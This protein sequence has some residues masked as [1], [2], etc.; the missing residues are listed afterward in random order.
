VEVERGP[1]LLIISVLLVLVCLLVLA[2]AR[3]AGRCLD[4]V[5]QAERRR[6][7]EDVR[8]PLLGERAHLGQEELD[9]CRDDVIDASAAA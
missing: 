5:E 9:G 4:R 6:A 1:R 2:A 8:L 7:D 3:A